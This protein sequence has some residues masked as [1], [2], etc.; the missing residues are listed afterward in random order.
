M[1]TASGSN[2]NPATSSRNSKRVH[3]FDPPLVSTQE[4]NTISGLIEIISPSAAAKS[5]GHKRLVTHLPHLV[6]FLDPKLNKLVK[7]NSTSFY[8]A[9]KSEDLRSNSLAVPA[10]CRLGFKVNLC[11]GAS[12]GET[13]NALTAEV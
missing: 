10:S 11:D 3:Y 2:T 8:K 5:F 9:L 4:S 13:Y 12:Q 6:N 7:T 1:L